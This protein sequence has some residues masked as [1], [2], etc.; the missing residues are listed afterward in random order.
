MPGAT[1]GTPV[2]VDQDAVGAGYRRLAEVR[3]QLA[4]LCERIAGVEDSLALTLNEIAKTATKQRA[5]RLR[6]LASAAQDYA[7]SERV[8]A[9]EYSE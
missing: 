9:R 7:A 3:S 8:R 4:G 2:R 6:K 1:A 5:E